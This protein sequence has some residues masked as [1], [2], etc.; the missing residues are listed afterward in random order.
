M[1]E[2]ADSNPWY[3]WGRQNTKSV[4]PSVAL[5]P[6]ATAGQNREVRI[7]NIIP[8]IILPVVQGV[9]VA[10]PSPPLPSPPPSHTH[11]V[12]VDEQLFLL[13]VVQSVGVAHVAQR[14]LALQGGEHN[15]VLTAA[16]RDRGGGAVD[17]GGRSARQGKQSCPHHILPDELGFTTSSPSDPPA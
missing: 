4:C 16:G 6:K 14:V 9:E 13:L 12:Q 17:G 1:G 15:L 10:L 8:A 5:A 7:A 3:P 11:L 2:Q